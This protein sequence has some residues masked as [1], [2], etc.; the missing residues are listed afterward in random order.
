MATIGYFMYYTISETPSDFIQTKILFDSARM[1]GLGL[2]MYISD[3][4]FPSLILLVYHI[5]SKSHADCFYFIVPIVLS[6]LMKNN[7][8]RGLKC[9]LIL[10]HML[11]Y[12]YSILSFWPAETFL[13]FVVYWLE[14]NSFIQILI[15]SSGILIA[16]GFEL[17]HLILIRKMMRL[18]ISGVFYSLENLG[19]KLPSTQIAG[20]NLNTTHVLETSVAK[21]VTAWPIKAIKENQVLPKNIEFEI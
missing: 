15:E 21:E 18:E 5:I 19:K 16:L 3:K 20:S 13:F 17:Y 9:N 11:M 12:Q 6:L 1:F 8:R 4:F 10:K 14:T 7:L 2:F